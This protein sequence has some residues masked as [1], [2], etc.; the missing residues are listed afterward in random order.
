MSTE[1]VYTLD[2]IREETRKKF[3]P[4]VIGLSDDTQVELRSLLRLSA[5]GRKTV[6]T[7]LKAIHGV[8]VE[9]DDDAGLEAL[10]E[11]I[12]KVFNVIAD[13]PAK[14]LRELDDPELDIKVALMTDVLSHW[15]K[16]TQLGEAQNS[17]A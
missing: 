7:A 17:P 11:Q 5:E 14:L 2:A 13:K 4:F 15:A 3:A 9:D 10:V 6:S 16:A 8:E 12:S 1:N